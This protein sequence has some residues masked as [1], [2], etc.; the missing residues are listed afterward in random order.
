MVTYFS[1][2]MYI[3]NGTSFKGGT[4]DESDEDLRKRIAASYRD[5]SNGANAAYYRRL[6]ESVD[7]V[8]SVA[9]IESTSGYAGAS[10]FVAG[11]G[12]PC[13]SECLSEVSRVIKQG[14]CVGHRINVFNANTLRYDMNVK[15]SVKSGYDGES[16]IEN[17]KE[18][19]TNYFKSLYVGQSVF[20]AEIGHAIMNADGV[21]N[22]VFDS[23]Q[24]KIAAE[25][26]LIIMGNL[27]VGNM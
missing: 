24:D 27:T 12:A 6:A 16:V 15:I 4:D 26:V 8:Q 1:V 3:E 20:L 11:R 18:N 7:G 19:I 2:G 23:M 25:S 17:V 5:I 21:E 10:V 14:K 9:V 13:T 22:Y